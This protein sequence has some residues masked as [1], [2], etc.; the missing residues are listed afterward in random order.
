MSSILPPPSLYPT[1]SQKKKKK[2][3]NLNVI[4][5]KTFEIPNVRARTFRIRI[6]DDKSFDIDIY[7]F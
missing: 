5:H 4:P 7:V 2:R 6:I 3:E 1:P